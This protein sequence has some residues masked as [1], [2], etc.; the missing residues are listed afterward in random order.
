MKQRERSRDK[1]LGRVKER[2]E[3]RGTSIRGNKQGGR[4][5]GMAESLRGKNA[6]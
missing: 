4:R 5:E 6:K 2:R 1:R 3:V